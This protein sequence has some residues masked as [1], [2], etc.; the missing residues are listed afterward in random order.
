MMAYGSD[1]LVTLDTSGLTP[2][3]H[4]LLCLVPSWQSLILRGIDLH[5]PAL[6]HPK[7]MNSF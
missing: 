6:T 5:G 2:G 7:E 3:G 1:W 4:Y